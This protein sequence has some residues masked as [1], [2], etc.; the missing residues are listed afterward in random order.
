MAQK[1]ISRSWC[2]PS[3]VSM[4]LAVNRLIGLDTKSTFHSC[5][6]Q[7]QS[8]ADLKLAYVI[9]AQSFQI[10]RGWAES[11][12]ANR[13]VRNNC[14]RNEN[15]SKIGRGRRWEVERDARFSAMSG[16]SESLN[17]MLFVRFS[18]RRACRVLP[19]IVASF[20]DCAYNDPVVD[21]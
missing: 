9:L 15:V 2:P 12:R 20:H 7:A 19:R 16:L 13:V 21:Q 1:T 3:S 6:A 5:S 8:K 10:P 4:P 17:F 18:R 11:F 14:V